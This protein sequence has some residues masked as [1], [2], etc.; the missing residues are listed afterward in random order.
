M[1]IDTYIIRLYRHEVDEVDANEVIGVV[2]IADQEMKQYFTRLE[3]LPVILNKLNQ[4]E[5]QSS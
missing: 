1:L 5:V 4:S 2:E 3:E